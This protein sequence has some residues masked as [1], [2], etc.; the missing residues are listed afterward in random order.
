[1]QPR[2]W[3]SLYFAHVTTALTGRDQDRDWLAS[4][5]DGERQELTYV[6][7]RAPLHLCLIEYVFLSC[8]RRERQGFERGQ[9]H[10]EFFSGEQV[11]NYAVV[12]T[13]RKLLSAHLESLNPVADVELLRLR[14]LSEVSPN[15]VWH[16]I[17]ERGKP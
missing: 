4:L 14:G 8:L 2:H 5:N 13:F 15:S 9:A 16:R 17:S 3:S 10:T 6:C 1:M 7:R 11:Y 12:S